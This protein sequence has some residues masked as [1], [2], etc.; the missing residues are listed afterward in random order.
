MIH[1]LSLLRKKLLLA[2]FAVALALL[3]IGIPQKAEAFGITPAQYEAENVLSGSTIEGF[4]LFT[5]GGTEGTERVQVEIAGPAAQY[6]KPKNGDIVQFKEGERRVGFE[7]FI[8][9][10]NLA[11]GR[12]HATV[13][14]TVIP[15]EATEG[16]EG[17]TTVKVYAG[18]QGTIVFHVTNEQTVLYDISDISVNNSE[19]LRP[20]DFRFTMNNKGN[21]ST[22]PSIIQLTVTDKENPDFIFNAR[23]D[24]E[25]IPIVAPFTRQMITAQT[26]LVLEIGT[27]EAVVVFYNENKEPIAEKVSNF[28]VFPKGSLAQDIEL[29]EFTVEKPEYRQGEL[30]RIN[31][32]ANNVGESGADAK[33]IFDIY[34]NDTLI[35]T[36]SSE[37]LFVA[38]SE[39]QDFAH[40][41][42]AEGS[43]TY[44]VTGL[45]SYGVHKSNQ[46]EVIFESLSFFSANKNTLFGVSV[47]LIVVIAAGA[48][49]Y[50]FVH[51]RK[52]KQAQGAPAPV[53]PAAPPVKQAPPAN[54]PPPSTG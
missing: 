38:V 16:Q 30:V 37:A 47:G 44:R 3:F 39:T 48:I 20:L 41:F 43:G 49:G 34:H 2:V 54:Q 32:I 29:T 1:S 51:H 10:E 53:K 17:G 26:D 40:T 52:A 42:R 31:A 9:P 33:M 50:S 12:Y 36:A 7:F 27:Y 11:S 15:P 22:R 23:V 13:T 6:I 14:G 46:R 8:K 45:L 25:N 28:K 24:A 5:R 18:A 4:V 21:V 19:E 35:D